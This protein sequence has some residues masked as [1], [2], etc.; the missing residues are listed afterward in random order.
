MTVSLQQADLWSAV[1]EIPSQ[2]QEDACQPVVQQIT[3]KNILH[4]LIV[5]FALDP[6]SAA[7]A[8]PKPPEVPLV[9]ESELVMPS[10]ADKSPT[11]SIAA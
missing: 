4:V 9:E 8:A 1:S 7:A 2:M 11:L 6:M 3:R 10:A 5:G